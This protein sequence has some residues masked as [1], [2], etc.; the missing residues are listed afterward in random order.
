MKRL[1]EPITV[2]DGRSTVLHDAAIVLEDGRVTDVLSRTQRT[3]SAA[4]I[5]DRIDGSGKL[6]IP[7]LVNAHTH[8]YSALARGMAISGFAPTSFAQILEQLWWRLDKALHAA[9]VRASALVGAMEAA[10]CGVTTLIDHHASPN[11]IAGSLDTM[12]RVVCDEIGMR[13]VFCYELTDRD[14]IER[15]DAGIDENLRF[16]S[17]I[18][19]GDTMSAAQFG[20]HAAF[21]LSDESLERVADALP[22]GAG[23]HTHVAEGPEDEDQTQAKHGETVIDRLDRF[24]L[25]RPRSILAHCL[26]LSGAEKDLIAERDAMVV[27]NPRSNMNNA[28][29]LFDLDGYLGRGILTGLGTDGLGSNMLGELF[30][31]GILQKHSRGEP[32]VGS[33]DQLDALLFRGNPAIVER[34]LG[35]RVG[36]IEAGGP[37]DVA[38][39]DYVPP[40]PLSAD[41]ILGH[42]LFGMAVHTLRVSDLI[43]AGRDVIRNGRFVEIDEV[44]AYAMAREAA[45]GLWK[46]IG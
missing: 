13:G 17:S 43:V 22:E 33:F 8:L 7:G 11:A 18:G 16:L 28:V 4:D 27:H 41:N 37:A 24:G 38:L 9:S 46:R 19:L 26:H 14:G 21:T 45:D 15:R 31:A 6:A 23:V 35:V 30:T 2:W 25:L 34:I 3:G 29:G 20:L 10:R 42:L 32:L 40:T 36:R 44:A 39:L 12:R 1:I 5:D